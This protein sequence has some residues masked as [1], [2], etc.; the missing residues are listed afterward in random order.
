MGLLGLTKRV[1]SV[2]GLENLTF[3]K[4]LMDSTTQAFGLV[5]RNIYN[6]YLFQKDGVLTFRDNKDNSDNYK[7][8]HADFRDLTIDPKYNTA[9]YNKDSFSKNLK[10]IID[11]LISINLSPRKSFYGIHNTL[12]YGQPSGN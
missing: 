6:S 8:A 3:S 12:A 10:E 9:G 1:E 2:L 5:P 11:S 4:S 7:L